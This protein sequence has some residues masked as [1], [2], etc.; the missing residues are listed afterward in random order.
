MMQELSKSSYNLI[1]YYL[2][3]HTITDIY[4]WEIGN[5]F[6]YADIVLSTYIVTFIGNQFHFYRHKDESYL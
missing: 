4:T 3:Y 5:Q 2:K 6:E 1:K